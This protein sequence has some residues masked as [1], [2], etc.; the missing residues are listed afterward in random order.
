MGTPVTNSNTSAARTCRG[1]GKRRKEFAD[2]AAHCL[3]RLRVDAQLADLFRLVF[4]PGNEPLAAPELD[5]AFIG[6]ASGPADC[7]VVVNANQ[8]LVPFEVT[9]GPNGICSV[10]FHVR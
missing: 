6:K 4:E 10:V 3:R 9:I 8:R 1:L 2:S 5:C 7:F